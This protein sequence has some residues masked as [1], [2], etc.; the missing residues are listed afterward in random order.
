V[1]RGHI[2]GLPTHEV[3]LLEVPQDKVLVLKR[4]GQEWI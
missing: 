4:G 1:V 2:L 3:P